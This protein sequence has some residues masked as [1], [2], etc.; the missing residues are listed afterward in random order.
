VP[1]KN[2]QTSFKKRQHPFTVLS[3]QL[4]IN[5]RKVSNPKA[6]L[7]AHVGMDIAEIVLQTIE[8]I[9]AKNDG[10][11][12]EQINDELIIK[13]LELGFLDLLKKEYTDLTPLL[14]ENFDYD[15]NT[16][17]YT[18]KKDTKFRTHVDIRLRVKYYL[19]S[20]LRRMERENKTP[21]FDEII[22]YIIPLLKNGITPENQTVLG[23]LEDI[24]EHVGEDCWRLRR[25]GQITLFD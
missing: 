9:I 8:G 20:Y 13:G 14:L 12:L 21:H 23:V 19:L 15:N 24:A 1:Q 11:T 4:I 5:F 10:A 2:G 3:G 16:E 6:I 22:L 25:K 18:I 7:K 17:L